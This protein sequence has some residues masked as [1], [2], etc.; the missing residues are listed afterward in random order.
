MPKILEVYRRKNIAG[1]HQF[2]NK[3]AALIACLFLACGVPR[4]RAMTLTELTH[5]IHLTPKTLL[6]RFARFKFRLFDGV[7]PR[8]RFLASQSGDCDDFATLAADV[9]RT[10]GYHTRLVAV[11]M[12]TQTHVVC[13]VAETKAYLDYNNRHLSEP[14]VATDG[15]L[16]DIA[17][18][19]ARSFH[20][21]WRCV[22]E[23]TFDHGVQ[24][25]LRTDFR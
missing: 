11:F 6:R 13:A 24:R 7:Q 8:E 9:L 25:T 20:T 4:L 1:R 2:L 22:S 21:N 5:D 15:S 10:R 17:E 23:Y 16:R 14:L 12:P 19:V 18:K 3:C